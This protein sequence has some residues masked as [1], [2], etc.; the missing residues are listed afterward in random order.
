MAEAINY[1]QL[2]RQYGLDPIPDGV[3]QLTRLVAR[4]DA[5]LEDARSLTV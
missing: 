5:D 2:A 4:K 1:Q 3:L